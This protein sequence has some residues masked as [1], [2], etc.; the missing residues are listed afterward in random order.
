MSSREILLVAVALALLGS[1]FLSL[2]LS[3]YISDY[4]RAMVN[5]LAEHS[6]DV[7]V[8]TLR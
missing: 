3:I 8:E 4:N 1:F 2:P 5:C 7:C 6:K